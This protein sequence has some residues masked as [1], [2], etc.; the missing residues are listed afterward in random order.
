M[1]ILFWLDKSLSLLRDFRSP[2]ISIAKGPSAWHPR[3]MLGSCLDYARRVCIRWLRKGPRGH[4]ILR[5]SSSLQVSSMQTTAISSSLQRGGSCLQ[6]R[7]RSNLEGMRTAIMPYFSTKCSAMSPMAEPATTTRAPES[8]M[9]LISASSRSSSLR[10]YPCSSSALRIST[11]PCTSQSQCH[12]CPPTIATTACSSGM[13][14][15]KIKYEGAL[16]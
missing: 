5:G 6:K 12:L 11:V 13:S 3:I 9:P 1:R 14:A 16:S 15:K 4:H 10:L 8:A 2:S 7:R